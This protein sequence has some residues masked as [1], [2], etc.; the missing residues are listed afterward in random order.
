M[1]A[2]VHSSA[3]RDFGVAFFRAPKAAREKMEA[4]GI[5]PPS[6]Q[7]SPQLL[8]AC[9]VFGS[10]PDDCRRTGHRQSQR[11]RVGFAPRPG[12]AAS[13][14]TCCTRPNRLAGVSSGTSR[15]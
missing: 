3:S 2:F 6:G 13:E 8:R 1:P 5:E 9:S 10:R 4:G 11:P 14:L 12:H 15:H 7:V